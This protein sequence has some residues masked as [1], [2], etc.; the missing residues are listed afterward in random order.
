MFLT[1]GNVLPYMAIGFRIHGDLETLSELFTLKEFEFY[2]NKAGYTATEVACGWAG[3]IFEA[4]PSFGQ[5][6]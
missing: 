5:E 4:T 1:S 3:A 6:Q 2:L